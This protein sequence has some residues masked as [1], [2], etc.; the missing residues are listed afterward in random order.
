M[1]ILVL[2]VLAI[3]FYL[4]SIRLYSLYFTKRIEIQREPGEFTKAEKVILL[5]TTKVDV[6]EVVTQFLNQIKDLKL[7]NSPVTRCLLISGSH[8]YSHGASVLTNLK[9]QQEQFYI[10]DCKLLGIEAKTKNLVR[11]GDLPLAVS[12]IPDICDGASSPCPGSIYDD[13]EVNQMTFQVLNAALYHKNIDKI[14]QDIATFAPDVIM[15][16]W[17]YSQFGDL[18][19]ALRRSALFSKMI[20]THDLRVVTGKNTAKLDEVQEKLLKEIG[21]RF[22]ELSFFDIILISVDKPVRTNVLV[23]GGPGS[24]KTIMIVEGAKVKISK[25]VEQ[26]TTNLKVIVSSHQVSD[27]PLLLEKLERDFSACD[28]REVEVIFSDLPKICREENIT[29][30]NPIDKINQVTAKLSE[31]NPDKMII[32][33]VDEME[34]VEEIAM[35]E[36]RD[37]G[38]LEV[39]ENLVWLIALQPMG[40]WNESVKVPEDSEYVL[41]RQ[42][43][44]RYRMSQAIRFN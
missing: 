27:E 31:D 36:T 28:L 6:Y 17:C 11:K 2:S 7:S 10:D 9:C 37:W 34:P 4:V 41:S 20:M 42:L 35:T 19:L 12:D 25:L 38:G 14:V 33:I 8:Q 21:M 44:Y 22:N 26:G 23:R 18:S 3:V 16:G 40:W 24:G 5:S 15:I 30:K 39:R 1:T 32:L 13:P 29:T 43:I